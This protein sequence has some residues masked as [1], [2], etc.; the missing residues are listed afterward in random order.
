MVCQWPSYGLDHVLVWEPTL[1]AA[2]GCSCGC[3]PL[4]SSARAGGFPSQVSTTAVGGGAYGLLL[5]L[6]VRRSVGLQDYYARGRHAHKMR[7]ELD[8][9]L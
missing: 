2:G 4:R 3:A 7:L 8:S 1:W 6:C 9:S 5:T